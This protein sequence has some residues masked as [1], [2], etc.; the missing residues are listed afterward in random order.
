MIVK[1]LEDFINAGEN[2][3]QILFKVENAVI[4]HTSGKHTNWDKVLRSILKTAPKCA[5][6]VPDMLKWF[7]KF[8]GGTSRAFIQTMGYMFDKHVHPARQVSGSI[9]KALGNL[10]FAADRP[11][12]AMLVNA[13]LIV[14]AA[15]K[16]HVVDDYA[17]F[18]KTQEIES[19]SLGG[20]RHDLAMEC[21]DRLLRAAQILSSAELPVE[22]PSRRN[23]T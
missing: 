8:G 6:D 12:P 21:N 17:R 9:F 15:A 5:S 18:I 22:K 14:H 1:S 23:S 16:E 13:I 4:Q 19:V 2:M 20:K 7:E 3:M 11:A 10:K